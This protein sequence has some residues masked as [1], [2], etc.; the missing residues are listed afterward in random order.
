M[1]FSLLFCLLFSFAF[2]QSPNQI[3]DSCPDSTKVFS[4]SDAS[5]Q[6]QKIIFRRGVVQILSQSPNEPLSLECNSLN[7]GKNNSSQWL[8]KTDEKNGFVNLFTGSRP[9]ITLT[10]TH[11]KIAQSKV[12]IHQTSSA[13]LSDTH[14]DAGTTIKIYCRK[15]LGEQNTVTLE[16]NKNGK[17]KSAF[18]S[19]KEPAA[20][21][22]PQ[23]NC[24]SRNYDLNLSQGA[25]VFTSQGSPEARPISDPGMGSR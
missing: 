11:E 17:A 2:A 7:P 14:W 21:A 15:G 8:V 1:L 23:P 18:I 25:I 10:N 24:T 20:T 19:R 16:I 13:E 6:F 3:K 4:I 5:S 12:V 9:V 22:Q